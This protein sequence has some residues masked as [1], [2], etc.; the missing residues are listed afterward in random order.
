MRRDI[1]A[2]DYALGSNL[3][4]EPRG[5]SKKGDGSPFAANRTMWEEL[6][7]SEAEEKRLMPYMKEL[8]IETLSREMGDNK[9]ALENK[10][11]DIGND[12]NVAILSSL[13][14]E[15]RKSI[16]RIRVLRYITEE[17]FRQNIKL[18]TRRDGRALR[19]HAKNNQQL[20]LFFG[21]EDDM[22]K[23]KDWEKTAIITYNARDWA[24]A[25]YATN[26]PQTKQV[27]DVEKTITELTEKRIMRE[28]GNG[29]AALSP[30]LE[31]MPH[32]VVDTK[33]KKL[34]QFI[35][36]HPLFTIALTRGDNGTGY[37]ECVPSIIANRELSKEIEYKLLM[38]LEIWRTSAKQNIEKAAKEGKKH[39]HH[40]LRNN[41]LKTIASEHK[42]TRT[43]KSGGSHLN[44]LEVDVENAFKKMERIG[45]IEQNSFKV[46]GDEYK[47][48]WND[49]LCT[50]AEA[51]N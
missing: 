13:T 27:K 41:L 35:R 10:I 24:R 9:K 28:V 31:L 5:K 34:T 29:Y 3:T 14:H 47:F 2:D 6:N 21:V 18:D 38:Q 32:S 4:P 22:P 45:I 20:Q 16:T 26:N 46:D 23:Y 49:N 11:I 1:V 33:Q 15:N 17:L 48:N 36:L 43:D 39:P 37:V 7:K 12:A 30:L 44:R 8:V 50:D 51:E 19:A 42:Y 25:I 40:V